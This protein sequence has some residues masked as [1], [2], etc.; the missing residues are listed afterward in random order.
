MDPNNPLA[1]REKSLENQW[2][3]NKECV[4]AP[5][6]TTV[7]IEIIANSRLDSKWPRTRPHKLRKGRKTKAKD[8]RVDKQSSISSRYGSLGCC[9]KAGYPGLGEFCSMYYHIVHD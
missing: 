9:F 1:D 5:G 8:S 2:I 3:K 4:V 6:F 7:A